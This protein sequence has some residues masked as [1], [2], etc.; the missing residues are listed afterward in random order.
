MMVNNRIALSHLDTQFI[1][2]MVGAMYRF[3]CATATLENI[4]K[5]MTEEE[6]FDFYWSYMY[7]H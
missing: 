4:D 1:Q 5:L 2:A 3:E 7:A 6:M